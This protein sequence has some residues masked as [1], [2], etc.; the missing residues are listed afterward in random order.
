VANLIVIEQA[1]SAGIEIGFVEYCKVGVPVTV[2]TLLAGW[3][4]LA[5]GPA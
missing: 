1:R 5:L 2:V 4:T 3:L